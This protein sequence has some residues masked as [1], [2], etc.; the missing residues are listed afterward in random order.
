[1]TDARMGDAANADMT[2]SMTIAGR[3]IQLTSTITCPA[4]GYRSVET[5]PTDTC[6]QFYRCKGCG[7][8]LQPMA[9]ECC[10]FC[11]YGDVPCPSMQIARR[12]ALREGIPAGR[13]RP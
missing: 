6:Q 7:A 13:D 9:N 5:M 10:V 12:Q 1:M 2:R 4:C 11:S 8:R 3:A